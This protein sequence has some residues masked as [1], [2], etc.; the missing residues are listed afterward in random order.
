[1]QDSRDGVAMIAAYRNAVAI[2]AHHDER[3]L[4]RI[5]VAIHHI[6]Q[7]SLNGG[8][9]LMHLLSNRAQLRRCLFAQFSFAREVLVRLREQLGESRNR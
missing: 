5:G 1:M 2:A 9:L 8:A 7:R 4:D 3:L 6:G